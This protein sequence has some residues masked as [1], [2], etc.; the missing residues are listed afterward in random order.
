MT[1]KIKAAF[2]RSV[3]VLPLSS[4]LRLRTVSPRIKDS[5]RYKRIATSLREVGLIEPLVV[6]ADKEQK[7]RYLL[8]DGHMR[9]EALSD[10]GETVA[11]CLIADDDEAFTYNKRVNRLATVQEHL[12]L[13]RALERGVPEERL[14]RSLNVEVTL[15][16]RRRVMLDGICSEVID[17]LSDKLVSP[18]A[19]EALRKVKPMRQ[20]ECAELM[21]AAGNYGP[22]YAKA[23]VGATRQV[24][25]LK[26]EQPKKIAGLPPE[27]VARMEREM[28]S[29]QRDF[30]QVETTYG[31]DVLQLV[32]ASGFISKLLNNAQVEHY[33]ARHHAELLPELKT[34]VRA[35]SLTQT[36][37]QLE[38]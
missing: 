1:S 35:S 23:L 6:A 13:R 8:L 3:V 4:L 30:K 19:F 9:Y 27:Q 22:S 34:I 2:G 14:A 20:I 32:I 12:M 31:E 26:P 38:P 11:R 17:L 5:V 10:T 16:K 25:L 24:D 21:I 29:L 28:E 36:S 33:L 37:P 18:A 7:N 15:I